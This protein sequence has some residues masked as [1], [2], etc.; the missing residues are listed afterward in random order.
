MM[1]KLCASGS[2]R[3][4]CSLSLTT[5]HA[6]EC[7]YHFAQAILESTCIETGRSRLASILA[8]IDGTGTGMGSEKI[9]GRIIN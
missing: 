4:C 5:Y 6:K 1:F 3:R 9:L 7:R 8:F 2:K